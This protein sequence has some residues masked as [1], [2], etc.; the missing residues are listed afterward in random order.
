MGLHLV[1]MV[2]SHAPMTSGLSKSNAF[3]RA[4]SSISQLEAYVRQA[5][6]DMKFVQCADSYEGPEGRPTTAEGD[7]SK[8]P[9]ESAVVVVEQLQ[10]ALVQARAIR[11]RILTTREP[12]Q[13]ASDVEQVVRIQ[14]QATAV[15]LRASNPP[16]DKQ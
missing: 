7:V 15:A 14:K 1:V 3:M 13:L 4:E 5:Q 11:A 6:A 10:H 16:V 8:V 2:S 9:A 12:A